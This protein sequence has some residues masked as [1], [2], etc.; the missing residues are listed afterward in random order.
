MWSENIFKLDLR[1]CKTIEDCKTLREDNNISEDQISDEK[2]F[3]Y[4]NKIDVFFY[5]KMTFNI[6]AVI[7]TGSDSIQFTDDFI[8][9][10]VG[11]PSLRF[12][13]RTLDLDG[14]LDKINSMGIKSLNSSEK[15]F[16]RKF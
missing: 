9:Y 7:A 2:L 15:R 10:L 14:I 8:N 12:I 1:I 6:I 13:K 4:K 3:S 5:D 11:L 16:L